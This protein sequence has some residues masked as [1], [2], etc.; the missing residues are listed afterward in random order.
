MKNYSYKNLIFVS[1]E[2]QKQPLKMENNY[3]AAKNA[4][5]YGSNPVEPKTKLLSQKI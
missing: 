2:V 3:R 5:N 1:Y 4:K